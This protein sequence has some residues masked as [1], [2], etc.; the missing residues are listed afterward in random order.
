MP[1]CRAF[2]VRTLRL[3]YRIIF[4]MSNVNAMQRFSNTRRDRDPVSS[5]GESFLKYTNESNEFP[6][7]IL[8]FID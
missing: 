3:L 6:I 8:Y 5:R 4:E 2:I 7:R 1:K